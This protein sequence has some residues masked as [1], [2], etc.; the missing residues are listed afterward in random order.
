MYGEHI[1]EYAKL[2]EAEGERVTEENLRDLAIGV[3]DNAFAQGLATGDFDTVVEQVVE[4]ARY[5]LNLPV[6]S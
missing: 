1:E 3:A 2:Y 6:A 4:E 5:V